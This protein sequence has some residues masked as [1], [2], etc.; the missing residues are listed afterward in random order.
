[1]KALLPS[2]ILATWPAHLNLLD[3][4]TLTILGEWYKLWSFFIVGPSPLAALLGPNI[5]LRILYSPLASLL[6][7]NIHFRILFSKKIIHPKKHESI[8]YILFVSLFKIKKHRS[9][10][11]TLSPEFYCECKDVQ[12]FE[13]IQITMVEYET[14]QDS[15]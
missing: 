8:I 5:H 3:L 13:W 9:C 15:N 4:F 11:K 1:M 12:M 2:S 7:P 6:G 10:N 14:K